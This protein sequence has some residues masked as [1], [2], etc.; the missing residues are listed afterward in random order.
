MDGL[1]LRISRLFRNKSLLL[2]AFDHGQYIGVPEGLVAIDPV[3]EKLQEAPFD[4]YLLNPGSIRHLQ[5]INTGKSLIL[6]ITHAGTRIS[7][8]SINNTYFLR[9]ED[10]LRLGADAVISMVVLGHDKDMESIGEL[11]K[12][13][14]DYHRLGIPLIAE[15]LPAD[16]R[17]FSSPKIVAD[18]CRIAAE[19]G[20][21]IIKTV[22]TPEFETVVAGCPVPVIVAGGKKEDNFIFNVGAAM[23][24][25][26]KG[27]AVGRNLYQSEDSASFVTEIAKAMGRREYL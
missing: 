11:A 6:R 14:N 19:I 24:S 12:A 10:A 17:D 20:A 13:V 3:L 7:N 1:E 2:L 15:V 4:G 26:A 5:K 8:T 16:S 21:D 25:G 18:I 23:R 27:V 9:P 22:L